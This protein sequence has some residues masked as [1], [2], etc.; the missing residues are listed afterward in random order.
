MDLLAILNEQYSYVCIVAVIITIIALVVSTK[1]ALKNFLNTRSGTLKQKMSENPVSS[2][3]TDDLGDIDNDLDL[4][5][6]KKM[7]TSS[8]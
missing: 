1:Y 4:D 5:G 2:S 7:A 6:D 3:T 8:K